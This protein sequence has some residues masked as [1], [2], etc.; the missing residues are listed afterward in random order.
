MKVTSYFEISSEAH[1]AYNTET[2]EFEPAYLKIATDHKVV[3]TSEEIEKVHEIHLNYVTGELR[4]CPEHV[5]TISK[6]EYIEEHGEDE[7]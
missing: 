1:L 5:R 2:K 4:I 3:L 6:E 7:D